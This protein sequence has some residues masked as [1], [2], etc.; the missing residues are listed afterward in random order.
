[1][2]VPIT[3]DPSPDNLA[4]QSEEAEALYAGIR[5]GDYLDVEKLKK[6]GVVAQLD[7][8]SEYYRSLYGDTAEINTP[9]RAELREKILREFLSI[10]SAR[11]EG[12]GKVDALGRIRYVYDGPLEKGYRVEL[13]LGLPAS[14]KSHRVTDPDSC[15]MR[16]F[17]LDCDVIKSFLPEFRESHGGAADA[18]HAESFV[19]MANALEAF[20]V[21]DMKGTNVVLPNVAPDMDELMTKYIRPFESAGYDVR[22]K[23]VECPENV[24]VARNVARQLDTGRVF[25]SAVAFSFGSKP[26]EVYD[27]L[28]DMIN[29]KGFPYGIGSLKTLR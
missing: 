8:L 3:W 11:A 17:I 6:S 1:M 23:F 16:A 2:V 24:S 15:A 9:E 27:K 7:A 13:V 25:A 5:R 26:A 21:G 10:G 18:V 29:S 4:I 12:A 19:I 14:G 22:A 28:K 20:T